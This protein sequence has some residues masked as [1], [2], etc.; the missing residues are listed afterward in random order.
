M[1]CISPSLFL[2]MQLDLAAHFH[3]ANVLWLQFAKSLLKHPALSMVIA[4]HIHI[5][6]H[7]AAMN[8]ADPAEKKQLLQHEEEE[9]TPIEISAAAFRVVGPRRLVCWLQGGA[10][11][12]LE[13][14]HTASS[15]CLQ[16]KASAIA[17]EAA[18]RAHL[19]Q[20]GK[21]PFFLFFMHHTG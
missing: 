21:H 14:N 17:I 16:Q 12:E 13:L 9:A 19:F 15:S 4:W 5:H 7:I 8:K 10:V 11:G 3:M 6:T 20:P 18:R 1:L 2:Q